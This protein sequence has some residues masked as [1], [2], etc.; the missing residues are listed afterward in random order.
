VLAVDSSSLEEAMES[1]SYEALLDRGEYVK[2][3]QVYLN[4]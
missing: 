1:I 3:I 4:A 2:L